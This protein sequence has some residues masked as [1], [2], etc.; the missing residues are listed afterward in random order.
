MV[1]NAAKQSSAK[2]AAATSRGSVRDSISAAS[3]GAETGTCVWASGSAQE[4]A[5]QL[6]QQHSTEL[7][8]GPGVDATS[9]RHQRRG[10]LVVL[11][12]MHATLATL[13]SAER[14]D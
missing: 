6:C 14:S 11:L 2:P 12:P 13:S 4:R 10:W 3:R 7:D 8:C 9:R 5:R 1:S